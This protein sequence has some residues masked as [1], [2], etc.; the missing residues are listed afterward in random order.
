MSLFDKIKKTIS[1]LLILTLITSWNYGL[2]SGLENFS[3]EVK[4]VEAESAWQI[5][6]EINIVDGY[7]S[8]D[9][10]VYATSSEIILLDSSKYSGTPT[11]YFEVVASTTSSIS[12]N[13]YL[14]TVAGATVATA[15][16]P[17]N[18][19]NPTLIRSSSFTP[20]SGSVEYV[21]VV[22]PAS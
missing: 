10:A 17:P 4:K 1:F 22:L 2:I 14:K 5:R 3:P 13:V 8:A 16:I 21:R 15:I 9:S 6:Q 7:V 12:S 19:T 18:T 11:Y 20:T